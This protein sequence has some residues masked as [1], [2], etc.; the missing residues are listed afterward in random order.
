MCD[1]HH[2]TLTKRI[3]LAIDMEACTVTSSIEGIIESSGESIRSPVDD[4]P[5]K[6]RI[7]VPHGIEFDTADIINGRTNAK[8]AVKL[9]LNESYGHLYNM[10]S[11]Y[12]GPAH[13]LQ[14]E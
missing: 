13:N 7:Q 9:E 2:E 1:T 10:H 8:T 14:S 3:N 4:S 11:T 6:V 12:R 5:H